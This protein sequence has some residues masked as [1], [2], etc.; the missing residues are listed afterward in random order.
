MSKTD[1]RMKILVVLSVLLFILQGDDLLTIFIK[2]DKIIVFSDAKGQ[3]NNAPP[4]DF[5]PADAVQ[6]VTDTVAKQVLPW[7]NMFS[8]SLQ[9]GLNTFQGMLQGFE[10]PN[11][12]TNNSP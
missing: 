6:S 3:L 8:S 7:L 12:K 10:K 2:L 5:N 9:T 1:I 4:N 11:A